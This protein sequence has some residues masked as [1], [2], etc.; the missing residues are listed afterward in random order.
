MPEL[1]EVEVTRLGV[2]PHLLG[3]R[4]TSVVMR[5]S[6]LRWPFPDDLEQQLL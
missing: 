6:G 1:P 4:V 2:S 5:R 3:E